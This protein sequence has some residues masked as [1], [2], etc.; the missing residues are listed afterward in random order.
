[1]PG[2]H[3]EIVAHQDH[4]HPAGAHQFGEQFEDLSLH[5]DIECGGRLVGDEEF[6]VAG[7]GRGDGDALAETAGELMR[8]E[9]QPGSRVRDADLRQ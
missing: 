5:R 8:I 4:R 6:G 9:L 3:T 7:Q 2:D 1:M